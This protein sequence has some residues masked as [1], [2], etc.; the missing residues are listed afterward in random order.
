MNPLNNPTTTSFSSP[1]VGRQMYDLVSELYPICRSITGDGFR[2]TLQILQKHIPLN[3]HEVP[4]GTR[5]FDW[6]VPLEWNIQ[7]AYIKNNKGKR[8]VDFQN[9][10]LHVVNYSQPIKARMSLEELKPHLHTVPN[11]P[12][13]IPYRTSYYHESWGFCLSHNQLQKLEDEEYEVCIDSSLKKGHLTYGECYLRGQSSDEIL[14]SCHACHPSLC[15][16][17]LS[18]I[19]LATFLAKRLQSELLRYSY[20]FIFIPATI[21]SI[22]WLALNEDSARKIKHG[23]VVTGVGD[24]G[25]MTYKKTRQGNTEID[26]VFVHVLNHSP[27]DHNIID[28]FPYGYDERQYC[29]PGFN[30]PVGCFMRTP[31]GQYSEYHTSGDNLDFVQPR[32]LEES[33]THCLQSFTLLE[34]NKVYL[35]QNPHCEPQ[36]GRRGLYR[37][38]AGQAEG[39]NR[40]MAMLWVL[41]LTDGHHTLLDIAEQSNLPF[42]VVYE[43]AEVLLDHG[44]L[45][46]LVH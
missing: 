34:K 1:D 5:V 7:D 38:I 3:I 10:N 2:Q 39:A 42:D 20:R 30:L 19:A 29:S 35:N 16:D 27:Q 37:A 25:G 36:L 41:N 45:K 44:L 11:H 6:T 12:D 9:S 33:F 28:F 14:I 4:S 8:I 32:F 40:E 15:N 31:H 24:P 43:T 13:W 26:Q 18:G 17:N 21:G 46:E 23:L 22:T